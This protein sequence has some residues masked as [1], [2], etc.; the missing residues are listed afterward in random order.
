MPQHPRPTRDFFL[1]HPAGCR[2]LNVWAGRALRSPTTTTNSW[3]ANWHLYLSIGTLRA[4]QV[5]LHTGAHKCKQNI[6]KDTHLK[7][8]TYTIN[9]WNCLCFSPR[10]ISGQCSACHHGCTPSPINP[11]LRCGE[12]PRFSSWRWPAHPPAS[13]PQ[14]VSHHGAGGDQW[15]SN[16][17]PT[18]WVQQPLHWRRRWQQW[19]QRY[20]HV[21][22]QSHSM[23]CFSFSAALWRL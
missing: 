9:R 5:S 1:L 10:R 2:L 11:A 3:L 18:E 16:I 12:S 6:F 20:S 13:E 8:F 23:Y 4:P 22:V 21:N 14:P 17:Q 7:G 19:A 15:T